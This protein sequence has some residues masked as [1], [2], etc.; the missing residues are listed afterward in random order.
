MSRTRFRFRCPQRTS[1][2]IPGISGGTGRGREEHHDWLLQV[3]VMGTYACAPGVGDTVGDCRAVL[4]R[5]HRTTKL[6]G[7]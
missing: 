5:Q 3:S 4:Q 7:L 2:G 1:R 6:R